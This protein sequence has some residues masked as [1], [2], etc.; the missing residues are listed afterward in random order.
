MISVSRVMVCGSPLRSG[1]KYL[2]IDVRLTKLLVRMYFYDFPSAGFDMIY[3]L[4]MFSIRRISTKMYW[5]L[6]RTSKV[7]EM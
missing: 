7:T 6:M 3:Y 2:G 4:G 1:N 5:K